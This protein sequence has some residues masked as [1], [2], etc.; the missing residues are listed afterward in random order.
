MLLVT[1]DK[2]LIVYLQ[3]QEEGKTVQDAKSIAVF[4]LDQ[5]HNTVDAQCN[6]FPFTLGFSVL[7]QKQVLKAREGGLQRL[8]E[9]EKNGI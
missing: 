2:Q 4:I 3:E 9:D 1:R 6:V 5:V 8:Q 7:Q